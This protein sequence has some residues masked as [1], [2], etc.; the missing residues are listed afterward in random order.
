[1]TAEDAESSASAAEP[2]SEPID[3]RRLEAIGPRELVVELTH[4]F[5]DDMRARLEALGRAH[6]DASIDELQRCAHAIK[7]SCSNFGAA[8]MVQLAE[9]LERAPLRSE[10]TARALV[11]LRAEFERVR[12][13]LRH[14]VLNERR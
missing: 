5:L 4:I 7:G 3:G 14:E 12:S 8:R 10:R 13:W 9:G 1:M 11:E 2:A 6:D